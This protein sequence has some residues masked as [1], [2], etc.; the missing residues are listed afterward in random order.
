[1]L[2]T[3]NRPTVG[4]SPCAVAPHTTVLE[5]GYQNTIPGPGAAT[6]IAAQYPQ[7][8]LRYGF[9]P[10][11][12]ID[13]V[14]PNVTKAGAFDSGVAAK[15]EFVPSGKFT[16]ALDGIYL[17]PNGSA[18]LTAGNA[19]LTANLDAS[20]ALNDSV[21]V[22]TTLA[23]SSTGGY[24]ANGSHARYG[25]F[26]PSFVLTKQLRSDV[27][28]Y[29]EYVYASRIAPDAGGRAFVDYGVQKLFGTRLE[30]DAELGRSVS[31]DAASA[32]RYAG[33]GFGIEF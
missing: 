9:A 31:A 20:Y 29:G 7:G 33:F 3:L 22:G 17:A 14:G 21:S 1:M 2:A 4:Y 30:V 19:T 18:A 13:V 27:Q 8:F 10:R 15:Y 25:L 6:A 26:M 28:A 16:V 24:A 32:F 11:I 12:E 5:V 23:I